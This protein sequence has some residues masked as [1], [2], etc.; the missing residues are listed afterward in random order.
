[1]EGPLPNKD[2]PSD[3]IL[4]SALMSLPPINHEDEGKSV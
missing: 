2:E 3:H 1:V 4:I